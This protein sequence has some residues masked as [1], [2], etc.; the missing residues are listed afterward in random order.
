MSSGSASSHHDSCHLHSMGVDLVGRAPSP[1]RSPWLRF[2]CGTR[3][4]RADLGVRPTKAPLIT[5]I[6]VKLIIHCVHSRPNPCLSVFICGHHSACSLTLNNIPKQTS[7]LNNELPPALI[8][9]SGIP[10]VGP[11]SS[12][13]LI[14]I[15]A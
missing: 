6:G 2:T 4:S 3:A 8:I 11:M 1:A 9:G 10:L 13:T 12:T 7:V 15:S 5:I 14:L